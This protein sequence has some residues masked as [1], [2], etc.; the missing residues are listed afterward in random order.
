MSRW[1][2]NFRGTWI[3]ACAGIAA[4]AVGR[5]VAVRLIGGDD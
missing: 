4:V 5:G 2:V 1:Q 3:N